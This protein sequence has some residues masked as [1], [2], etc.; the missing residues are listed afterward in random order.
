MSFCRW[1]MQNA[2]PMF[3]Q[4]CILEPASDLAR[5]VVG[6]PN[7]QGADAAKQDDS[8]YRYDIREID[9][10]DAHLIATAPELAEMLE[11][12]AEQ[13]KCECGHPACNRCEDYRQAWA[14]L[15]KAKGRNT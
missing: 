7:I 9:H 1:G 3:Q 14:V 4:N 2:Q 11:Q 15:D 6:N 13:N 12:L 5:F 10:P 8:V